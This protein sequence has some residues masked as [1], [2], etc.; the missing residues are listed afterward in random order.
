MGESLATIEKHSTPLEEATTPSLEALQAY[1]VGSSAI[2]STFDWGRR[3]PHYQRAVALDP[4]F[5][6]AHALIGFGQ[7][8]LGE[9]T[10]GRQSLLTAYQLRQR[11]S[12]AERFNIETLYDR[13]YTGNLERERR[14]LDTWTETY[15]RELGPIH[16]SR[17]SP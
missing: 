1:S 2:R 4:Q 12:D 10:L 11:A 7:S 15:P 8:S 14:T 9:S 5:A 3:L 6:T 17:A 13:D 16:C